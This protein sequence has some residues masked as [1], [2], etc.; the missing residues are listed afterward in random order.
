[1]KPLPAAVLLVLTVATCAGAQTSS[2]EVARLS[3]GGEDVTCASCLVE[4]MGYDVSTLPD[5]AF[6]GFSWPLRRR[7]HDGI[8]LV[9]YVDNDPSN[10]VRDYMG[11]PHSYNG[12]R[13]TDL[14][15][16]SFRAMDRGIPIIAVASGTVLGTIY[17]HPD[18]NIGPPYPDSGNGIWIQHDDGFVTYYWHP[19]TNSIAVEPGEHVETGQFLALVGSS[20]YSTDAHLHFE[21]QENSGNMAVV[22]DPWNG[23]F[24]PRPSM[25]KEQAEYVGYDSLRICE[26]GFTTRDGVGGDFHVVTER[27][28]KEGLPQP[29]TFGLDEQQLGVWFLVQGQ[30][31]DIYTVSLFMPDSTLFGEFD[32]SLS[33]KSR[34][35]FH[36]WYWNLGDLSESDAGEWWA[37][38]TERGRKLARLAIPF[39]NETVFPPKFLPIAGRSFRLEGD[40]IRDTLRVSKLGEPVTFRLDGAPDFVTLVDSIVTIETPST[41]EYRSLFFSAIAED[42]DGRTDTMRYH[43]VDPSRPLNPIPVGIQR[44]PLPS[45]SVSEM[46]LFPNPTRSNTSVTFSVESGD[47]IQL[48]LFDSLGR[49]IRPPESST[50]GPGRHVVPIRLEGLASGVYFVTANGTR[51]S[52]SAT[53]VLAR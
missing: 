36:T 49:R 46:R 15:L 53:L 19:R 52:W 22:R 51:Y 32:Y 1:M 31:D 48:E 41:Q 45:A 47:T 40:V 16:F 21:V 37:T 14:T 7:I 44:D 20:G 4:A 25:W 34:Y 11:E 23:T 17:R 35:A 18:R 28:L 5:H 24:N 30:E 3:I 43:L 2:P 13:G 27:A 12:H 29:L 26:I 42:D 39:S 33:E 6:E 50:Y 38:V 10:L 9:N 8:V